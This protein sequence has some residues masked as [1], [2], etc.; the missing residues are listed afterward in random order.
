MDYLI[1]INKNICGDNFEIRDN[2]CLNLI[3]DYINN[4][5]VLEDDI[6][7]NAMKIS[8]LIKLYQPFLDGNHRTALIVF[9]DLITNKGY[10][11]D[12]VSALNDMANKKLNIPTIYN[13]EDE[14]GSFD[15]WFKY[16]SKPEI[17]L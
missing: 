14:V 8:A 17:K 9:G 10:T 3:C 5:L 2:S 1:N 12:Y 15:K 4:F 11:F 13:E 6:L 7:K 16:I